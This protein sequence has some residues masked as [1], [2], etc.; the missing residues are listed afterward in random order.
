MEPSLP[1]SPPSPLRLRRIQKVD[2][3][4]YQD[5]DHHLV[6]PFWERQ[7][8]ELEEERYPRKQSV[9]SIRRHSQLFAFLVTIAS[10][11]SVDPYSLLPTGTILYA[12][13]LSMAWEH[14]E[15]EEQENLRYLE[16]LRQYH[17]QMER[18]ES[19][20]QKAEFEYH[21]LRNQPHV[22]IMALRK[23]KKHNPSNGPNSNFDLDHD[24]WIIYADEKKYHRHG[25]PQY[26]R[27]NAVRNHKDVILAKRPAPWFRE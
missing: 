6:A 13:A 2:P 25:P 17:K 20:V 11:V 18:I 4:R 3:P 12:V 16:K 1:L 23:I 5:F 9:A 26:W 22:D 10:F 24:Q 15:N 27:P 21:V 14:W 19:E 7:Q 8:Q